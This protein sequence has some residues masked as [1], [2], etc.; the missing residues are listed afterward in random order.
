MK[1]IKE[2]G[3]KKVLKYF[4]YSLWQYLFSAMFVS[5]LRVFLLRMFGARIG[6]DTVIEKVK[7]INLYSRGLP[8]LVVGN[9][10]FLGDGVVLDMADKITL[11]DDVTLSAEVFVLTHTNVGYKNHPLQKSI[12][13][14]RGEVNFDRGAFVGVRAIIMP[15]VTVGERSAVGA[16]TLVNKS[17]KKSTLV[18][19]IPAKLIKNLLC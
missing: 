8:G 15:G 13:R 11:A 3:I 19:G 14:I 6:V 18:A 2:I 5:P 17:V 10:C 7:F 16:L 12:M 4:G 1:A 9:R